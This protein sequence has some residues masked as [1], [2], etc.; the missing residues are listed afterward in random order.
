MPLNIDP[1]LITTAIG[2]AQGV[3]NLVNAGDTKRR[4]SKLLGQR[5]A[6]STPDEIFQILNATQSAAQGDTTTRDFQTNE[7]NQVF[8]NI[9]NTSELL[10]ADP[11]SLS[12]LFQSKI[13]GLL[14]IGEQFHTSNMESFGK[15]LGALSTVADNRAAEW[16]SQQDIIKDKLQAEGVNLANNYGNVN[17]GINTLIGGLSA[18][19]QMKLYLQRNGGVMPNT[20][21][22]VDP[23]DR[24]FGNTSGSG[25]GNN[26]GASGGGFG[27]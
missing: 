24:T 19:Q 5:Q 25:G 27:G 2:A 8:S 6:Y 10:G 13:G 20:N 7:L 14:K 21:T 16:Q 1:T 11:N 4:I 3:V 26:G 22:V 15:Y 9:L 17:A 18:D 23:L 12:A